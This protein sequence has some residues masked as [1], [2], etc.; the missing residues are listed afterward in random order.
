MTRDG[1]NTEE[2]ERGESSENP[3]EESPRPG[4]VAGSRRDEPEAEDT[5]HL[6]AMPPVEEDS[7]IDPGG[8]DAA[9]AAWAA[10]GA[11]T[12]E[13]IPADEPSAWADAP[14]A[15]YPSRGDVSPEATSAPPGG[16]EPAFPGEIETGSPPVVA[17]DLGG[18]GLEGGGVD[19]RYDLDDGRE[20]VPQPSP[21]QL[22]TSRGETI[23][24][25]TVVEKIAGKA[26]SE[27]D[28]VLG[29]QAS[30]VGKLADLLTGEGGKRTTKA[31]ADVD[32]A[33]AGVDLTVSVRYPQPVGRLAAQVRRHVVARVQEMTGLDVTEINITVPE[34]VTEVAGPERR[35]VV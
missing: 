15:P 27:V 20:M 18:T 7:D 5:A 4:A 30:G 6:G 13:T 19:D 3:E 2:F 26:A 35:R 12:A 32:R 1:E 34:L 17:S 21:E 14:L 24:T 23:I 8:G 22:L 28:G 25:P 11:P 33:S 16:A 31:S 9:A 10:G 29:V